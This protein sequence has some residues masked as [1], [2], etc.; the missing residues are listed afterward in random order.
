MAVGSISILDNPVAG[1]EQFLLSA[2]D[3]GLSEARYEDYSVQ[4]RAGGGF[5]SCK[6]GLFSRENLLKDLFENGLGRHV[7][8]WGEG[9]QQDFEGYI[10]EMVY[11]LPPDKFTVNLENMVNSIHMRTDYDDD[12]AVERSTTLTNSDSD[13]R[14]G[15]KEM[16]LSGG[17][18]EGLSVADQATQTFIDLRGFPKPEPSLGSGRGQAHIEV[19]CRGYIH[20]LGWRIYNQTGDT[21]TQGMSAQV[22]DI[23]DSVGEFVDSQEL[24]ANSTTVTVE[25]DADRKALDII[26]NL[27]ALGDSNNNRWIAFMKGKTATQVAGRIFVLKEAAPSVPES[28]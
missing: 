7:E 8:V 14:F 23:L 10:H 20:T 6:F 16:V 1:T 13:E 9:L 5:W 26:T 19:F 4:D 25:Y 24:D 22:G 28:V 21:G 3:S 11:T 27:A 17:E 18:T 15:T 2:T 12:G